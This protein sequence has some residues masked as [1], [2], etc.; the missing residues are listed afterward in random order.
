MNGHCRDESLRTWASV[1]Y[2]K[3]KSSC[4]ISLAILAWLITNWA[5]E[6][7]GAGRDATFR[8]FIRQVVG[9]AKITVGRDGGLWRALMIQSLSMQITSSDSHDKQNTLWASKT[10]TVWCSFLADMKKIGEIRKKPKLHRGNINKGP[11][12][13]PTSKCEDVRRGKTRKNNLH[14]QAAYKHRATSPS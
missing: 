7:F 13:A 14:M 4:Q 2:C 11:H 12:R 6:L 1:Q 3:S 5:T 9:F 8:K 10:L